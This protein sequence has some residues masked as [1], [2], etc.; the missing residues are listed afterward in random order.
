MLINGVSMLDR[1]IG[2]AQKSAGYINNGKGNIQAQVCL[3]TP[4]DDPIANSYRHKV[5]TFEGSEEDVLS[6]YKDACDRMRPDYIVRLTSDCPMLPPFLI[7]KHIIIATNH[8]FDYTS[9]V[10]PSIRTS[11]DGSDVEVISRKLLDWADKEATEQADREHV[12]TIIRSVRPDWA[13]F[14]NL[15]GYNDNSH[16]KLSVDEQCDLDFVRAY[17]ELLHRKIK[18]AKELG[19]GFFRV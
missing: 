9:N 17:D 6:R 8:G 7:T 2:A 19:E 5:T 12:T 3:L 16:L 14:A 18:K 1:V 11:F 13:K 4:V 10:E 15:V